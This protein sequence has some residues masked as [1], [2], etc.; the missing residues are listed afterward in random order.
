VVIFRSEDGMRAVYRAVAEAGTSPRV[1]QTRSNRVPADADTTWR[2][3]SLPL[4][5][6]LAAQRV[7]S[8][9]QAL[10]QQ[11]VAH[12]LGPENA[13]GVLVVMRQNKVV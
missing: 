12:S 7:A 1:A 8:C 5:T 3:V 11:H 4:S 13:S 2:C 9:H 6:Q 10:A